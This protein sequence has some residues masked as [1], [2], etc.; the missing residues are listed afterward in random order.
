MYC[1]Y[2]DVKSIY[3]QRDEELLSLY[4]LQDRVQNICMEN[5]L[6]DIMHCKVAGEKKPQFSNTT[7]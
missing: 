6:N 1:S 4:S 7:T 5:L 2:S 3:L